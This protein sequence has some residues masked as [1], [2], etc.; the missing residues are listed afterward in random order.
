MRAHMSSRSARIASIVFAAAGLAIASPAIAFQEGRQPDKSPRVDRNQRENKADKLAQCDFRP[1]SWFSGLDVYNDRNE[2]IADVSDFIINRGSGR[3]DYVVL[4]TGQ[5]MGMG[6]KEITMP[7]GSLRW[8]GGEE[9]FMLSATEDQLSTYPEFT[10]ESWAGLSDEKKTTSSKLRDWMNRDQPDWSSD[11]YAGSVKSGQTK[12][13]DGEITK[14][15]RED[16]QSG[17]QVVATVKDSS[18]NTHRVWLGPSWFV[19]GSSAA[20]MRGDKVKIQ[21]YGVDRDGEGN[22]V[23]RKVTING[24]DLDLRNDDGHA[25]WNRTNRDHAN[26][27]NDRDMDRVVMGESPN[28]TWRSVL[29]SELKGRSVICRG[30]ECGKVND[31]I[32]DRTSGQVAMMSIDPNQNFLGIADTKHLV[33]W[34]VTTVAVDGTLRID[35]SKEMVLASPAAP[36]D[37]TALNNGATASMVYKAYD[38]DVPSFRPVSMSGWKT[39]DGMANRRLT[40]D[41]P[42]RKDGPIAR[43]VNKASTVKVEGEVTEI[44]EVTFNNGTPA[45][46]AVRVKT[47]G[48][49]KLVLLCPASHVMKSDEH[50]KTGSKVEIDAA[51]VTIDGQTYLMARSV[52]S[53]GKEWKLYN[54]NSPIWDS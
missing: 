23:G 15:E 17:E 32:V 18:G 42:W 53:N 33:P 10:P 35:A 43:D 48:G 38:I 52:D 40:L 45:A 54:S 44:T 2:H 19:N 28:V 47:S 51:E 34:Q 14:L 27:N 3:I 31:I 39:E 11:P 26:K 49:E 16:T 4:K 24:K 30:Q 50:C 29:A 37:V 36:S 22:Y 1:H 5:T 20:P 9:R 13:I 7:Y 21:A 6:G 8:D 12:T 41:N 25:R 46:K